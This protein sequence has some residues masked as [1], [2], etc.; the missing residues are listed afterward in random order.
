MAVEWERQPHESQKAYLAYLVY[1]DL[2]PQR[3]L[4][5][6]ALTRQGGQQVGKRAAT[7]HVFRW[8]SAWRWVERAASWDAYLQRERD[9]VAAE[10]AALWEKRRLEERESTYSL[11]RR[12]REKVETALKMPLVQARIES[13]D[14]KPATIIEP[15]KYTLRD[16][17]ALARLAVDLAAEALSG[18]GSQ[19]TDPAD[20]DRDGATL[21]PDVVAAMRAAAA[22]V[23]LSLAGEAD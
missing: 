6:A 2:G 15:L 10:Q 9:Q 16:V 4:D 3:S 5:A 17:V 19:P 1:R 14:G 12:L 13:V 18:Y 8:S 11:S 20:D 21:S 7:S 23:S 22:H